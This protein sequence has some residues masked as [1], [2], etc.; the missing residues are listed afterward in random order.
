MYGRW[1]GSYYFL[2]CFRQK[3]GESGI[4]VIRADN[5]SRTSKKKKVIPRLD[6]LRSRL[7]HILQSHSQNNFTAIGKNIEIYN[8]KTMRSVMLRYKQ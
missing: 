3:K 4:E 7:Q 5:D 8:A 1:R 6:R 2:Y